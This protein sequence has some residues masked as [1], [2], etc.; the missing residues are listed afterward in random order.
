MGLFRLGNLQPEVEPTISYN[1][2]QFGE[3]FRGQSGTSYS[4]VNAK[5]YAATLNFGR[6]TEE[7]FNLLEQYCTALPSS[8]FFELEMVDRTRRF[9][10]ATTDP[11]VGRVLNKVKIPDGFDSEPIRYDDEGLSLV[12]VSVSVEEI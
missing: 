12:R 10:G 3:N 7:E 9:D 4:T 5:K 6:L 1:I 11:V 2:I 8:A